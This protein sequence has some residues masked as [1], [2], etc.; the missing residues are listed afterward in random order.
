MEAALYDPKFGYYTTNI[1]TVGR[2][3]DFSTAATLSNDLALAISGWINARSTGPQIS[4][5]ELGGG[6]GS[7]AKTILAQ[8]GFW[9]RRRW[10]YQI[11]EISP[12]LRDIQRTSLRKYEKNVRWQDTITD[13]LDHCDGR[14]LIF[15][16]ELVDAFP[17]IAAAWDGGAWQEI[18][19]AFERN[20]GLR[21]VF[22][23]L[24]SNR[25]DTTLLHRTWPAGQR[26]E[27]HDSYRRWQQ[28]WAPELVDGSVLTIDYGDERQGTLRGY[29]KQQ[30]IEGGGI[31]QRFGLQDLTAD[32]NFDDLERWGESL[33]WKTI[34]RTSQ[35][36]W[37]KLWAGS[38]ADGRLVDSND[39]GR[40]FQ[41]LEQHT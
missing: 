31:Y 19:V 28:S 40:A 18:R 24:E 38:S 8:T 15:S 35:A 25:L 37:I 27:I 3:G 30:R 4:V 39:A 32:V 7:L 29:F 13:A 33:G 36:D 2:C 9:E 16:N 6:D 41:V 26:V 5:I 34:D 17:V 22:E 1:S 23:P 12:K 11:I 21:E 10:C 14:A 20:T